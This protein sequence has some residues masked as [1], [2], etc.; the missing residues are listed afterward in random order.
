MDGTNKFCT[1]TADPGV[2]GDDLKSNGVIPD[3]KLSG[4]CRTHIRHPIIPTSRN[5]VIF[6]TMTLQ[7]TLYIL[8]IIVLRATD[9][10]RNFNHCIYLSIE[11][12]FLLALTK[13]MRSC[14]I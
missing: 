7:Y 4:Y 2:S 1:D 11:H 9:F 5:L 14:V 12:Y 6:V 3:R 10:S 13:L 8:I